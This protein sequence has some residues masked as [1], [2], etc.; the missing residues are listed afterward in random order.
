MAS[1][2]NFSNCIVKDRNGNP[3][4]PM[5]DG[6]HELIKSIHDNRITFGIGPAGTGKSFL[7]MCEAV[8]MLENKEISKIVL[9]RPA[10]EAGQSMGFMPGDLNEKYTPF[11][12]PFF[13]ALSILLTPEKLQRYTAKKMIEIQPLIYMRGT[14]Q[15]TF[16]VL[17]EAQ[18]C[19]IKEL[20]MVITRI[21]PGGKFVIN[22]DPEQDDLPGGRSGLLKVTEILKDVVGIN[23]VHLSEDDIV[24]DPLVKE[25]II[26]FRAA[27]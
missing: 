14:N 19:T 4:K 17:D 2:R 18:N 13:D 6:Q 12:A 16:L 27:K 21:K 24:R 10:V 22:G 5:T 25:A 20:K 8:H 11:L 26:A 7:A 23:T 1:P 9:T 15:D 3:V